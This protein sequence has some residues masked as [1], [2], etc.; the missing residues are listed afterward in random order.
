MMESQLLDI[1][2]VSQFMT[3]RFDRQGGERQHVLT[4][5]AMCHLFPGMGGTPV[6]SYEQLFMAMDRLGLGY[7]AKEQMFRRMVFNV[8]ADECDDHVKNFSFLLRRGGS[9]ELAP[10]YDLTGTPASHED[11]AWGN[12][13]KVHALTV[14]GRQSGISDDDLKKVADRFGIGTASDIISE[15]RELVVSC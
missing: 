12:F 13:A 11:D 5:A 15:I 2:G 7:D 14:N 4:F 9:W 8:V 3:R 1:D 10:A 6:A